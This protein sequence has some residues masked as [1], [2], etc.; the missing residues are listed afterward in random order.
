MPPG[1]IATVSDGSLAE[2]LGLR[3]GDHIVSINGHTPRDVIDVQFFGADD[4]LVLSVFRNGSTLTYETERRD[5]EPLGLDFAEPTFDSVRRCKNWCEFCFVSQMPGGLRASLYV[6]DDD[7]RY[8]FLFGS[9]VTLTNLDEPD[10]QRIG[11]QRLSPL[12]VSVHATEPDLRRQALG[13]PSAPDLVPQLRRLGGLGIK[14]HT[15]VVAVPDLNEGPHLDR[16]IGDLADLYP[17]VQSVS[18][19]PVGLT[20]FSDGNCRDHTDGE[21]R[22]TV[23]RVMS[24]QER[25]RKRLGAA[26]VYLSDEWYL[27]LGEGIPPAATYDGLDLTENGVGLVRRFLDGWEGSELHSL[28]LKTKVTA[29]L[30]TGELFAPILRRAVSAESERHRNGVRVLPVRNRFFGDSVTVAGLLTGQDVVDQLRGRELGDLVVLPAVMFDGP[31][32]QSLDEMSPQEVGEALG[33]AVALADSSAAVDKLI[34]F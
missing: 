26:F 24:W 29:V 14:V 20:R 17:E 27:R 32:G 25:L 10:W 28:V 31:Q 16:T 1:V 34:Q 2:R 9:Y 22:A 3:P 4:H 5:G 18:V 23:E 21:M 6:R 30:V 8:S 33:R 19:V 11:Q 12:Y 15:Q 13:N 7:Y